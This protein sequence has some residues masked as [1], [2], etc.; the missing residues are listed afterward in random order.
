MPKD[1]RAWLTLLA[2][3]V[4][5]QGFLSSRSGAKLAAFPTCPTDVLLKLGRAPGG[6]PSGVGGRQAEGRLPGVI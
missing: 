2:A 6:G 3:D 5:A 1:S 4:M